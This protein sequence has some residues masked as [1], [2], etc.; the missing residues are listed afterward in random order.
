MQ[1][2][3]SCDCAPGLFQVWYVKAFSK[4]VS[5]LAQSI[6]VTAYTRSGQQVEQ[7]IG[8]GE[9]RCRKR[10]IRHADCDARCDRART[11]PRCSRVPGSVHSRGAN[12]LVPQKGQPLLRSDVG[13]RLLCELVGVISSA[14]GYLGLQVTNSVHSHLGVCEDSLDGVSRLEFSLEEGSHAPGT[15][16]YLTST[17]H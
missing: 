1:P 17:V 6:E 5:R 9:E 4:H 7:F 3:S 15:L 10:W 16:L 12:V 2:D 14:R 8:S 11:N 13:V